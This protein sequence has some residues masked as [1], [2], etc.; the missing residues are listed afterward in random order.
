MRLD[1]FA[2]AIARYRNK[3][4]LLD[5][6]L[7]LLYFVGLAEPS[8]VES[9][10]PLTNHGLGND[11]FE[12]LCGV[13]AKFSKLVTTPHILTEVSNHSDKMKGEAHSRL[14]KQIEHCVKEFVECNERS[15]ELC[16]RAEFSRF[17]LTDTAIA[18]LAPKKFLVVTID[19]PLAGYL[20]AK[21]VDV[22][23]FNHL[24]DIKWEIF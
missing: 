18:A 23:N 7:L 19:F 17:G 20:K 6:N 1:D 4:V 2:P 21:G 15:A 10:K 16:G 24:R 3:G 14:C 13:I 9:F 22:I 8:A 11:A 5:T 12:I